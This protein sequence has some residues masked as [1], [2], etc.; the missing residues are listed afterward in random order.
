M[1]IDL[2]VYQSHP[3]MLGIVRSWHMTPTAQLPQSNQ[4]S[5]ED[6][7]EESSDSEANDR[8]TLADTM[9]NKAALALRWPR[10]VPKVQGQPAKSGRILRIPSE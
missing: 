3:P 8:T 5:D 2:D 7:I 1:Q 10:V 9:K 4:Q 6:P